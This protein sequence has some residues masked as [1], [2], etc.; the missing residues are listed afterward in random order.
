VAD[1]SAALLAELKKRIDVR[2]DSRGCDVALYHLG[3]NAY[4]AKIYREALERPGV[5][6]LHD[7]SL[8]HFLL[9]SLSREEYV[10]EFVYNYGEWSRTLAEDL[11][12]NRARSA[13]DPRYF[14][15]GMLRRV[16][17]RALAVIVHNP[18]AAAAVRAHAPEANVV[19][20]PHLV[21]TAPPPGAV[22]VLRK[23]ED[24]GAGPDTALFGVFGHLRESKR[25]SV[26]L[27]AFEAVR[28][29]SRAALLMAGEFAS[30]DLERA[31]GP[32]LDRTG[33]LRA[34]FTPEAEFRLL[35]AA[36]D[37]CVN[38]RYP[39]AGETSGIAMRLMAAGKPVIVTRGPETSR[40]PET[41]CLRVDSGPAEQEMLAAWMRWLSADPPSGRE[42]GRRA[43]AWVTR[44]HAPE[45]AA[46]VYVSVLESARSA[47]IK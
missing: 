20:I 10:A 29:E 14:E 12:R 44:H 45:R 9:G 8:H 2:L 34:G 35:A 31:L 3:N 38:L 40:F 46:E 33:V 6:V 27:H 15:Y 42:I 1:Y 11:W 43:A 23:R 36:I 26:V 39:G 7:A 21:T 18:G 37:T 4:H 22:D 17:A 47:I 30:P 16:A 25:L 5:V 13:A 28:R 41:A 24:L 32:A 19:E